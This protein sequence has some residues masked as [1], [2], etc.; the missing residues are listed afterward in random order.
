MSVRESVVDGVSFRFD[1]KDNAWERISG[2]M[3]RTR[4]VYY[5]DDNGLQTECYEI[6]IEMVNNV[7][8]TVSRATR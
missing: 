4:A 1:E 8:E 3:D 6:R 7:Y 5:F 2:S